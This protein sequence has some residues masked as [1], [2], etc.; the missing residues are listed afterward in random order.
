MLNVHVVC[1]RSNITRN[2]NYCGYVIYCVSI[3]S[4]LNCICAFLNIS[5]LVAIYL[6]NMYSTN[7]DGSV[8]ELTYYC[9]GVSRLLCDA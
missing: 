6:S 8:A 9:L 3:D 5:Y 2:D 4:R 1:V 7:L